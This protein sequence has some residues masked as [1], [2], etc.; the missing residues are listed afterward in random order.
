MSSSMSL[1]VI[2]GLGMMS[3][4]YYYLGR[5]TGME[6]MAVFLFAYSI[7][8]TNEMFSIISSS[9]PSSEILPVD[10]GESSRL[11][12]PTSKSVL[13]SFMVEPD[14][15][16]DNN[17]HGSA[18]NDEFSPG[19]QSRSSSSM[20]KKQMSKKNDR[21]NIWKYFDVFAG[22]QYKDYA[23]C[24]LCQSEVYYTMTMS[25]GMHTSHLKK[26]HR[27]EYNAM[28]KSQTAKKH[29]VD[30]VDLSLV[31]LSKFLVGAPSFEGAL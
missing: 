13:V 4:Y 7:N 1:C 25:T 24:T 28:V 2:T 17:I 18:S 3:S 5:V 15:A 23:F 21:S 20:M 9:N 8:V 31:S 10:G 11:S 12:E 27:E 14:G 19:D 26:F 30:T 16:T 29:K 6:K 22:S